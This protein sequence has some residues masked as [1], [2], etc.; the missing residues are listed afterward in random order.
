L[1]VAS[2]DTIKDTNCDNYRNIRAIH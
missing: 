2:M 1:A